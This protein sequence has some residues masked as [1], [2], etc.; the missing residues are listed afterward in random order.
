MVPIR[1][2]AFWGWSWVWRGPQNRQVCKSANQMRVAANPNPLIFVL[3]LWNLIS[4]ILGDFREYPRRLSKPLCY[5]LQSAELCITDECGRGD[6]R[7]SHP[8][9]LFHKPLIRQQPLEKWTKQ[10]F[11]SSTFN[12]NKFHHISVSLKQLTFIKEWLTLLCWLC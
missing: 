7:K 9:L 10:P 11:S 5:F 2:A 6:A 8:H 1:T 12:G 3:I 4:G